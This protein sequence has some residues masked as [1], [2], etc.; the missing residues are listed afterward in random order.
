MCMLLGPAEAARMVASPVSG[1]SVV[2]LKQRSQTAFDLVRV[3]AMA[4][5]FYWGA[6]SGRSVRCVVLVM[7]LISCC[8]YLAYLDTF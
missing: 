5:L 1:I 3:I 8:I 6:E 2:L 4:G 7:S